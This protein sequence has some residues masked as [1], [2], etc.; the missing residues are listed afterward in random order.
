MP[1]VIG[2]EELLAFIEHRGV[3]GWI[4]HD[5]ELKEIISL[6]AR[7]G[8][9]EFISYFKEHVSKKD[10]IGETLQY[11]GTN[12]V[13]AISLYEYE[14]ISG[15]K[16]E[17]MAAILDYETY[18]EVLENILNDEEFLKT[19]GEQ[20][21]DFIANCYKDASYRIGKTV[22]IGNISQLSIEELE[23]RKDEINI[24]IIQDEKGSAASYTRQE[25]IEVR[26][27][28]DEILDG[29]PKTEEGNVESEIEAFT[30][31]YKRLS[32]MMTYDKDAI[33]DDN[34]YNLML[35]RRARDLVGGLLNGTC[36]CLGYARILHE[37]LAC[38]GIESSIITGMKADGTVGH[39]WNQVKI[40][41]ISFNV[42]LTND[43]NKVVERGDDLD[44]N[45]ILRTD[46]E[47]MNILKMYPS[48]IKGPIK[49]SLIPISF[50][51]TL[52]Q[53]AI[54]EIIKADENMQ[55]SEELINVMFQ[56][57]NSTEYSSMQ[58]GVLFFNLASSENDVIAQKIKENPP[59]QELTECTLNILSTNID[60]LDLDVI[61]EVAKRTGIPFEQICARLKESAE[62]QIIE[63]GKI[64]NGS[65]EN[66][67]K[68]E[69]IIDKNDKYLMDNPD[70]FILSYK[71]EQIKNDLTKMIKK[72]DELIKECSEERDVL[73]AKKRVLEEMLAT[74][75]QSKPIN[76]IRS[77]KHI[78]KHDE[79]FD[80]I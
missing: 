60:I 79:E 40:G 11:S 75:Q 47:F 10:K 56:Y 16:A 35:A 69:E 8:R 68:A 3:D 54:E 28:I 32:R 62:E 30:E 50:L 12:I 65:L 80:E 63:K 57:M 22:E 7:N 72:I 27:K 36:V 66:R 41:G 13:S 29:V 70:D 73:I 34:R 42:D 26:K 67:K 38:A 21:V 15:E 23:C 17:N 14:C 76:D 78:N 20:A 18:S 64:I 43:R 74:L 1:E 49:D 24:I 45:E 37:V 48:D 4:W 46:I 31:I 5:E 9:K 55:I 52:P 6:L 59:N 2:E 58:R 77:R 19:F 44:I 71:I 61:T 25:Y 39:A 51:R 53:N 33:D